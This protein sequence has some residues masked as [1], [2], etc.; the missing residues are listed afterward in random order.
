[1]QISIEAPQCPQPG[2]LK[3]Y[4]CVYDARYHW[5]YVNPF[6]ELEYWAV[7][8][9]AGCEPPTATKPDRQPD[10]YLAEFDGLVSEV[11]EFGNLQFPLTR[12]LAVQK[13]LRIEKME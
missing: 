7:T 4:V 2:V 6:A 5:L 10:C 9:P 8:F 11:G 12:L 13:V 3:R 1:M